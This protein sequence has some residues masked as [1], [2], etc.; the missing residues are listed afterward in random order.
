ML[1][2][3]S[4]VR[5]GVSCTLGFAVYIYGCSDEGE[6]MDGK[7]G[8]EWRLPGLLYAGDFLVLFGKLEEDMRAVVGRFVELRKTRGLKVN[9][10]KSKVVMEMKGE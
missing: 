8:R 9:E 5:R 3:D 6:N 10:V 4:G 2:N 1:Q 7:E